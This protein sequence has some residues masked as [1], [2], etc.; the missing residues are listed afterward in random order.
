MASKLPRS[1][2][3]WLL[4]QLHVASQA[5]PRYETSLYGP[6]NSIL[7]T[8]FLP[9]QRFMVKPQGK[10]RP[11]YKYDVGE[12]VR[13]SFDPYN[14]PVQPWGQGDEANAK[15]PYFIVVK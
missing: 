5:P 13:Q 7:A 15:I 9:Q 4:H 6:V 3:D 2:P 1:I 12:V 8:Y 10:V 14:Q 11:G